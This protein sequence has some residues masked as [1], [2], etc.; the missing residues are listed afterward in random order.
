MKTCGMRIYCNNFLI[1]L[2]SQSVFSPLQYTTV[3]IKSS[4]STVLKISAQKLPQAS[5]CQPNETPM[6]GHGDSGP[7]TTLPATLTT[8]L[9]TLS[10]SSNRPACCHLVTPGLALTP[11]LSFFLYFFL[12]LEPMHLYSSEGSKGSK[13]PLKLYANIH[14]SLH[15]SILPEREPK[16][17]IRFSKKSTKLNLT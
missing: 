1:C 15:V 5:R 16:I 7:N 10:A 11:C 17:L 2:S 6:Q 13:N 3:E 8:T 9:P 4:Q 12:N 14:I